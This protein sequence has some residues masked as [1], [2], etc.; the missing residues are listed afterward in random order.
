[1]PQHGETDTGTRFLVAELL[2]PEKVDSGMVDLYMPQKVRS[3]AQLLKNH[4]RKQNIGTS[5][6]AML[7]GPPCVPLAP[8]DQRCR[9]RQAVIITLRASRPLYSFHA[10]A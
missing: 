1:M 4:I 3:L 7:R 8:R 9:F 5:I 10:G 2:G 6:M